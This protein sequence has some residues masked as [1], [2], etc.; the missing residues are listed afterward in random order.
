MPTEDKPNTETLKQEKEWL[1]DAEKGLIYFDVS[2]DTEAG[3]WHKIKTKAEPDHLDQH[4]S[5]SMWP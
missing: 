4:L 2:K 5:W 1:I 3:W